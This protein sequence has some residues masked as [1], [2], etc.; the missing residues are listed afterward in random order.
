M[1]DITLPISVK[2]FDKQRRTFEAWLSAHGSEIREP[3]NEYELMRFTT[4]EGV[5]VI[6][7]DKGDRVTAWQNGARNAFIAH[8]CG[9]DGWRLTPKKKR[10]HDSAELRH[11]IATLIKRDGDG[12]W[13]C[14]E[15]FVC[16][17]DGKKVRTTEHLVARIHGGPDHISNYV[18]AHVGCNELAGNRAVADKVRLREKLRTL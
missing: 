13:Y 2:Q 9:D 12:C 1:S 11:R 10:R 17:G 18:L 4:P 7:R 5:G 14:A 6:Y 8:M 16:G 15:P 3:S